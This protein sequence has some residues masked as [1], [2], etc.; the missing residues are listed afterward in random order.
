MND[1]DGHRVPHLYCGPTHRGTDVGF[2]SPSVQRFRVSNFLDE[3][4]I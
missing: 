3:Q 2:K 1:Y 4:Y